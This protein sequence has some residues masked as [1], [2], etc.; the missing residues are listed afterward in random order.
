MKGQKRYYGILV[1]IIALV[2]VLMPQNV[3]AADNMKKPTATNVQYVEKNG[4]KTGIKSFEISPYTYYNLSQDKEVNPTGETTITLNDAKLQKIAE[5]QIF[6][7]WGVIAEG[8]FRDQASQLVTIEGGGM[9]TSDKDAK[10]SF[11]RHFSYGRKGV[12]E[13]YKEYKWSVKDLAEEL[14]TRTEPSHNGDRCWDETR[15]TGITTIGNLA[16]ARTLMGQELRNCSDDDD[17][18]VDDF[19]GNKKDKSDN[20]YRLPDLA[21]TKTGKGFVNIV[22]CVNRAGGSGDYDYVTFGLAVY[23]FDI[24]PIAAENLKYIEAADSLEDGPSILM[25]RAGNVPYTDATGISFSDKNKETTTSYLKNNSPQETTQTAA[26]ENSTTEENSITT[27]ES[28]EWGMEQTV[29]TEL[30]FGGLG[31]EAGDCMFPRATFSFSNSWHELWNTMKGKTETKST[32]KTKSINTELTLPGHTV[33]KVT[34]SVNDKST[35]ENYQQPVV[36]SYKVAVFAMSGDY[37]NGAAGGIESNRYD[38]QWMSVLFD[39]SDQ[40]DT[41]GCYAVG[42][43]YNRAVINKDTQGYDGAVGKYR[44]WCDKGAWVPSRKINWSNVETGLADSNETRDSHKIISIRTGKKSTVADMAA[45]LPL[46]ERVS[47]LKSNQ[48]NITSSVDQVMPLYS[49]ASVTLKKDSGIYEAAPHDTFYLDGVELEGY[50]SRNVEFFGF[51]DD[52]GKWE[53]SGGDADYFELADDESLGKQYVKV[54]NNAPNEAALDLKWKIKKGNDAV[55]VSNEELV[56]D[57][58]NMTDEEK[59]NVDTPT[60]RLKVRDTGS[61][62]DSIEA[63]GSYKGLASDQINLNQELDAKAIDAS[64]RIRNVALYWEDKGDAPGISVGEN[65]QCRFSKAGTYRVRAY[66]YNTENA[67]I[68]SNWVEIQARDE[69]VLTTIKLEKPE[70][71]EDD[72]LLDKKHQSL[73]FPLYDYVACYDQYGEKMDPYIYDPEKGKWVPAVDQIRFS[74]DEESAGIDERGVLTVTQPGVH[75]ITAKA[76]N[77][78]GDELGYSINAIKLNIDR[79]NWLASIR[80]KDPSLSA[81]DRKLKSKDDV[82]TVTSLSDLLVYRD[83]SGDAWEGK[84]PDVTFSTPADPIAAEIRGD[85]FYAYKPGNYTI[86]ASAGDFTI[87]PITIPVE[88]EPYLVIGTLD[89]PVQILNNTVTETD[90]DLEWYVDYTTQFGGKWT[91]TDPELNFTL[92]ASV[93]NAKIERRTVTDAESGTKHTYH[94]FVATEPG[95]YTIHVAP[96]KASQYSGDIDDITVTV[97]RKKQVAAVWIDWLDDAI[98]QKDRTIYSC[99]GSGEPVT[100]K[101]SSH[102]GFTDKDLNEIDPNDS[103]ADIPQVSFRFFASE[104]YGIDPPAAEDAVI[105]NGQLTA[106]R[107]GCYWVEAVADDENI[108]GDFAMVTV[109]DETWLHNYGGWEVTTAPTCTEDGVRTKTCQGDKDK[110]GCHETL[111]QAIPATGHHWSREFVKTDDKKYAYSSETDLYSED[112]NGQYEMYVIRCTAEGCGAVN[113]DVDPVFVK[114][115]QTVRQT[116]ATCTVAGQLT[117]DDPEP[118]QESPVTI[119]KGHYWGGS[120]TEDSEATCK[121]DGEESIHCLCKNC[122]GTKETRVIPRLPHNVFDNPSYEPATC[123]KN[124]YYYGKCSHCDL[125]VILKEDPATGHDWEKPGYAWN[126]DLS[127]VTATRICRNDR[128]HIETETVKTKS[129][130]TKAATAAAE[131]VRTY[132]A[133]FENPAFETQIREE[134]IPKTAPVITA[135]QKV[136]VSGQAYQ[137]TKAAAGKASGEVTFTKGTNARSVTVPDKVKLADGREY[138]VTVVAEGAFAGQNIRTVTI[139]AN[140]RTLMPGALSMCKATKMIVKTKKLT[141]ASVKGSLKGS[142]IKTVKVKVGKKKVNKKYVKKYRKYFTKKNAGKKAAVK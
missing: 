98:E 112:E 124:G 115:G 107:P 9:M 135:G 141:K 30:N 21:D 48:E 101:L 83:Q 54:R 85:A 119:P 117:I 22:T 89:P 74:V 37:F 27:E 104:E 63:G 46:L 25:G 76:L 5:K 3:N 6:P 1:I 71:E 39:G 28:Y 36:L 82:V 131:G 57:K 65:G 97:E 116:P 78:E 29:G 50:N 52:W 79:Q 58:A 127:A 43:L 20:K 92:D 88:E 55:I 26:L 120:Y 140:V 45:E 86:Q 123:D 137:V 102:I 111:S 139:G 61:V 96:R 134:A 77:A 60:I 64:G 110:E 130:V 24:S 18:S 4:K 114:E 95:E 87:N 44:S 132:T 106:F 75:R 15:V 68:N 94:S 40:Q 80:M 32:S 19:L 12:N 38:K 100:I 35:Q 105:E 122:D 113:V 11:D 99:T 91:G 70:F 121:R 73:E 125:R 90:V 10:N 138:Q 7:K 49:L 103:D 62:I 67:R 72:L 109:C 66:C 53:V 126:S 14:G 34:Q 93:T 42:S 59:E 118:Q 51:N 69:S 81:N 84:K 128:T 56:A 8:I 13:N 33:A 129:S 142:K 31:L 133:V 108:Y 136:A 47:M 17:V 16:D 23:D 2:F 41:T